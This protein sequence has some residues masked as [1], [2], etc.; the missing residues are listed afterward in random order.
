VAIPPNDRYVYIFDPAAENQRQDDNEYVNNTHEQSLAPVELAPP[1]LANI[2]RY[3]C[4]HDDAQRLPPSL[5]Q[6]YA[7]Y[8]N[9]V[10][11]LA[12]VPPMSFAPIGLMPVPPP[13]LIAPPP[14]PTAAMTMMSPFVMPPFNVPPPPMYAPLP[15]QS[16]VYRVQLSDSHE[17]GN[18][19][20]VWYVNTLSGKR[21]T[22]VHDEFAAFVSTHVEQALHGGF[23][24]QTASHR[25]GANA[26]GTM[27]Q[28]HFEVGDAF[29]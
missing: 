9:D 23:A 4:Q 17:K 14:F 13:L 22:P 20:N 21:H 5:R 6:M 8:A 29:D 16:N 1:P 25:S 3:A 28:A 12:P 26:G 27:T 2:M 10:S 18:V 7:I 11:L 19:A 15:M 24:D